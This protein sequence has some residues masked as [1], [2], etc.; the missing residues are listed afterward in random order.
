M[1]LLS[2][3]SNNTTVAS[4]PQVATL[5]FSLLSS[6]ISYYTGLSLKFAVAF[7]S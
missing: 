7:I 1:I 5:M 4:K 2:T 6:I 3:T